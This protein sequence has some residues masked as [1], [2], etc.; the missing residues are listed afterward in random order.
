M[1][2]R[3]N[4]INIGNASVVIDMIPDATHEQKVAARKLLKSLGHD[5]IITM[6]DLEDVE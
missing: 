2:V 3:D 1:R 4:I 6:L 5:D